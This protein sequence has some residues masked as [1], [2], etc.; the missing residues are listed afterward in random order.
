MTDFDPDAP[1]QPGSGIFGL[2]S[3][4]QDAAVVL[5]PVPFEATTSYGGGTSRGPAAVLAA[6]AQVDLFDV[7]TGNPWRHG[8]AMLPEPPE[9]GPWNR[10]AKR[11]AR[12]V[13]EAGGPR[14]DRPELLA[15]CERVNEAGAN[16]NALVAAS[17]RHWLGQGKIF[18]VLGGDHAVPF[19]S[20]EAHA[21]RFPGMGILHI[22]AHADLRHAYE[23]F[24][25]SHASIMHNVLSRVSGVG[26]LVQVGIRDI[27]SEELEQIRASDGRIR[28]WFDA[29]LALGRL[30]GRSWAEQCARIVNDLPEQV[31]VSMDIDG[32]DPTL[33][34]HTGTPVPGGLSFHEL[35]LLL[36]VLCQSGRRIVGFDLDEVAP[37]PDGDEWDA[38]VGARV[39]YKLIGWTLVSQGR[40]VPPELPGLPED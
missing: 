21:E 4:P 39:L 14:P 5:L 18:G 29:R 40:E 25:W 16:L 38:N 13:I 6:S 10:A 11:D 9:V 28:A 17:A 32:L 15:A 27:G 3:T 31:Y 26:R 2:R 12:T 23:G 1:A 34:P 7:E 8:I 20:I 35:G 33:C 22:D 24:V 37:G 36:R 19:G 30:L